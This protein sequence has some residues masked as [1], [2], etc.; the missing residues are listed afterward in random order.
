MYIYDGRCMKFIHS[1]TEHSRFHCAF[2]TEGGVLNTNKRVHLLV[3]SFLGNTG[4]AQVSAL[5]EIS[6]K[7][8]I[9]KE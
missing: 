9:L 1:W 4:V 5:K 7:Y 3:H 2:V 6:L 8:P